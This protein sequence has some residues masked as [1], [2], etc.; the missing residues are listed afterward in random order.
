[1]CASPWRAG[2]PHSFV[3]TTTIRTLTIRPAEALCASIMRLLVRFGYPPDK[4]PKPSSW[5]WN[6]WSPSHPA[7]PEVVRVWAGVYDSPNS[8]P[9]EN[10]VRGMRGAL[11]GATVIAL[12]L[13][14]A[15]CSNP[16]RASPV[17]PATANYPAVAPYNTPAP[18]RQAV[19]EPTMDPSLAAGFDEL[20]N[21][22]QARAKHSAQLAVEQRACSA[23][24]GMLH[25][26]GVPGDGS[27]HWPDECYSGV[28]SA[29]CA[30]ASVLF[31]QDGTIRAA[32]LAAA[33]SNY[34]GCF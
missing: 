28:G 22:T 12:G 10:G 13:S 11:V 14:L 24:G 18:A 4:H 5:S 15:G 9:G 8:W 1:M 23:V 27:V 16:P 31:W 30:S 7:G 17:G 34:P 2:G 3:K 25:D 32:D 29:K 21:H 20:T 33:R 19:P 26:G 6:K